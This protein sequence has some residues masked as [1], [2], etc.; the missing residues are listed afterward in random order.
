[1]KL[2]TEKIIEVKNL[3]VG[4]NNLTVLEDINLMAY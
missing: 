4:Y 1:M 3:T 2:N